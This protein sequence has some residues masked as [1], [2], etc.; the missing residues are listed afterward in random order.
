MVFPLKEETI[1]KYAILFH[2][3][4]LIE[5]TETNPIDIRLRKGFFRNFRIE[6]DK[7]DKCVLIRTDTEKEDEFLIEPIYKEDFQKIL[8]RASYLSRT[9]GEI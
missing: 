2:E 4:K 7:V 8:A 9:L 5:L 1:D 6:E 3:K